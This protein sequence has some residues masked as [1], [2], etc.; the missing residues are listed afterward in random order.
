MT[1]I[2]YI[3]GRKSNIDDPDVILGAK[4]VSSN[5]TGIEVKE[6][7]VGEEVTS[8]E[9][10]NNSLKYSIINPAIIFEKFEILG[11]AGFVYFPQANMLGYLEVGDVVVP[12]VEALADMLSSEKQDNYSKPLTRVRMN[13]ST[14]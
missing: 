5:E 7:Y 8:E 9:L 3:Y 2:D 12:N 10:A 14:K 1:N 4:V 11:A 6:I 13:H